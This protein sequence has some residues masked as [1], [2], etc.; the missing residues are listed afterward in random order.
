MPKLLS[1]YVHV[2]FFES[3]PRNIPCERNKTCLAVR[4]ATALIPFTQAKFPKVSKTGINGKGISYTNVQNSCRGL[5]EYVFL[6]P[7]IA[8]YSLID[9]VGFCV[10]CNWLVIT[11]VLTSRHSIENRSI[12]QKYSVNISH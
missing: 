9:P 3:S 12:Y 7:V 11:L 6:V 10:H 1:I 2:P 8:T 4:R 5:L